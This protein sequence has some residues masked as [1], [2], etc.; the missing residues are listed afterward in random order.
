MQTPTSPAIIRAFT[1][2]NLQRVAKYTSRTTRE[3]ARLAYINTTFEETMKEYHTTPLI[4]FSLLKQ[5]SGSQDLQYKAFSSLLK[6][7]SSSPK[8]LW[9]L[10][11]L[12][13]A[14]LNSINN[15]T[16]STNLRSKIQER[17]LK[18]CCSNHLEEVFGLLL[19]GRILFPSFS[20]LSTSLD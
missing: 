1:I 8:T 18:I 2:Q 11:E 4:I 17:L 19:R 13:L 14:P 7:F 3:A 15:V 9:V 5:N 20:N 10:R 12:L 6:S 16:N